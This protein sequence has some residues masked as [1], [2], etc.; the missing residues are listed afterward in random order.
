MAVNARL[1]LD[2]LKD[3]RVIDF[4]YNFN[5]DIDA[6]GRPS[7]SVRGGTVNITI[8]STKSAFLP[9]WMTVGSGKTKSGEITISD[10]EDDAKSLKKIKF[11]DAFI[12]NYGE[13]FS[14]QGGENMM[15][16]F[17]ISAHKLKVD[18]ENGPAEFQ[19]EWPSKK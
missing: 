14:W 15:E 7:G 11:D 9:A 4:S 18:G 3:V 1:N 6:S 10:D 8:E 13:N 19:N 12:V 16:T 17:T 2:S 5:R